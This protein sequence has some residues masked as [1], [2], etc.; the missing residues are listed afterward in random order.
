M[1]GTY[2]YHTEP[3]RPSCVYTDVSGQHSPLFGFMIDGIPIYGSQVGRRPGGR[4]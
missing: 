3:K 2:H 1:S 4:A